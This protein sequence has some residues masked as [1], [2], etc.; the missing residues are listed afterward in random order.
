MRIALVNSVILNGGDAAIVYGTC[1]AIRS[2]CPGAA[3][4]VYARDHAAASPHYPDLSLEPMLQDHWPRQRHASALLR[5][6]YP[7]RS[8][9]RLTT[10]GE[11]SFVDDLAR[12]DALV[13]C[14][15]GYVN[16]LYSTDVLFRLF[17]ESLQTGRP[18]M[19][20][21]HSVGPFRRDRT[22]RRAAGLLS[23]FDAVTTRDRHSLELLRGL[24]AAPSLLEWTADAAFAMRVH[25]EA[26]LSAGERQAL[27][28]IREH[29]HRG[30]GAPLLLLSARPWRFPGTTDAERLA[31]RYRVELVRFLRL[32]LETTPWR[33]CFLSTCQGR[34]GYGFDDAAFARGLAA[35]VPTA[36]SE[37]LLVVDAPFHPRSYPRV[38]ALCADAVVSMRMHFAIFAIL[39]GVPVIPIA[40]EQKTR[41]LASQTGLEHLCFDVEDFV[42]E[43]LVGALARLSTEPDATGHRLREARNALEVRSR[44]NAEILCGLAGAAGA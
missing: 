19:A 3:V 1:D 23:R 25:D 42:A 11:R 43:D 29:R 38:V 4:T 24:D 32:V 9:L 35:E 7:T 31:A 2:A 10:P 36:F 5:R 44:R 8:R 33:L 12:Y 37:R 28:T 6:S 13:Y 21:A 20:Y 41:E 39:A 26:E 14:G 34:E 27:E 30:Q 16:D 18:H 15:G 40:Y 17:S 22:A